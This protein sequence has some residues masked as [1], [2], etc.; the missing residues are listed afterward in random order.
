MLIGVG[1]EGRRGDGKV[2]VGGGEESRK[3][4]VEVRGDSRRGGDG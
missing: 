3:G 1:G 2:G 4:G